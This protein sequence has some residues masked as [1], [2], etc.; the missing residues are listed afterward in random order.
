M[1]KISILSFIWDKFEH[2]DNMGSGWKSQ[3]PFYAVLLFLL[4]KPSRRETTSSTA[5]DHY[6]VSYQTTNHDI[7]KR[8]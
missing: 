1:W 5:V 7:N 6:E 3:Q 8:I 2:S 4:C